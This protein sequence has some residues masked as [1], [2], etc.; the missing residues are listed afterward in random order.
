MAE[1]VATFRT[2]RFHILRVLGTSL[3]GLAC[4]LGET[5]EDTHDFPWH[6]ALLDTFS[7]KN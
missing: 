2:D 5:A 1:E 3:D 6:L 4:A 7:I